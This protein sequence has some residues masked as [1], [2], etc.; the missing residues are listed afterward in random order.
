[1]S[2]LLIVG[3]LVALAGGYL[4]SRVWGLL[5][6]Q[7]GESGCAKCPVKKIGPDRSA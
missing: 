5:G 4:L 1:M 2:Q 3:L 6:P 7:G